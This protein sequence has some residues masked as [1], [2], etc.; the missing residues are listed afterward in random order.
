MSTAAESWS[1]RLTIAEPS[2]ASA[3]RHLR[4]RERRAAAGTSCP[5]PR[6]SSTCV[7]SISGKYG[8]SIASS[9]RLPTP[10]AA[11][12]RPATS[13]R[14]RPEPA[15]RA[16]ALPPSDSAATVS[17]C[18]RNA[19]PTR[20]GPKCE[21]A[22]HVERREEE[23]AEQAHDHEA[24][25]DARRPRG[26]GSAACAAAAAGSRCATRRSKN[27]TR[28]RPPSAERDDAPGRETTTCTRR[29]DEPVDRGHRGARD[30]D[31]AEHVDRR[32][33]GPAPR[34]SRRTARASCE[35]DDADRHVDQK[36]QCQPSACVSRPPTNRP[37]EPPE[38]LTNM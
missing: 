4:H 24:A 20:S 21:R 3:R 38:T 32:R 35:R 30:E 33:R 10:S 16:R 9:R 6:P 13:T 17:V 28:A 25:H 7:R 5:K 29:L 12:A 19:R 37:S 14:T 26:C 34:V 36:I 22:R 23:H 27:R 15:R 31:R 8:S 1:E 2:P 11:S 18:G